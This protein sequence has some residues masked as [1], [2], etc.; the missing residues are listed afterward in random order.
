MRRV[1]AVGVVLVM[2][3][4][5]LVGC[6]GS[7][8]GEY[9]ISGTIKDLDGIGL[10]EVNLLLEGEKTKSVATTD[11]NGKWSAKVKGTVTVIPRKEMWEFD[12]EYE[13]VKKKNSAVDFIGIPNLF[14]HKD[15]GDGEVIRT[16]LEEGQLELE[17]VPADGYTFSGWDVRSPWDPPFDF[18]ED[19]VDPEN[20][21]IISLEEPRIVTA[22]FAAIRGAYISGSFEVVH[23]FPMALEEEFADDAPAVLRGG[24]DA[25][26]E[27]S[28]EY[29]YVE[30]EFIVM[31]NSFDY[32]KQKAQFERAGYKVLDR[33][34]ALNSYLVTLDRDVKVTEE[35]SEL[36]G[37]ASVEHNGIVRPFALTIPDE[38]YYWAQWHYHQ[39]RLAQAWSVTTGSA[40]VRIGVVDTGIDKTHYQLK[41]NLDL[42][43]AYDFTMDRD[44]QDSGYHGTHVSGTIG[45]ISNI[46]GDVAGIMWDVTILP[47]KVFDGRGSATNWTVVHGMLYA[48]GLLNEPGKPYNPA[49]VDV[50]NLSLGGG[51]S[52]FEEDAVKLIDA[53]G[54]IIVAAAGND[55]WARVSYPA[56]HPE[57]IAVGAVGKVDK[58]DPRGY[59]EPPLASYSNWGSEIDIVAPGGGGRTAVKNDYVWSTTPGDDWGGAA[60]TSMAAPHVTGV[61]GLMLSNGI[62]KEQVR[63]ILYRTSMEINLP[64]P[65]IYFGHG[66]INAY[67]A[68][69]D[70]REIRFIQGLREGESVDVIA[71]T[72]IPLKGG[73]FRLDLV[74]GDYQF[75]AWIDANKNGIVDAGDYYAETPV[76]EIEPGSSWSWIDEI[77]EL[78][79]DFESLDDVVAADQREAVKVH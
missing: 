33:L 7:G 78:P 73:Q 20:P 34:E 24:L 25:A 61:V 28:L 43:N 14:I 65:N 59:T 37:V 11:E 5:L 66:L 21:I 31:F 71:E 44:V 36:S 23:S 75:I 46:G 76:L 63:E 26:D 41:D 18:V 48:A 3:G 52:Q 10:P 13:V 39:I 64:T 62:P 49:P 53:A 67:W 12:K 72:S 74:E 4:L 47:V 70:V 68:V 38:E 19:E 55:G 27:Y 69:N 22:Y 50:I 45:A 51:W 40:D 16:I 35:L 8:T 9:A 29:E 15:G 77:G 58:N 32:D 1:L 6:L 79:F 2:I 17:A 42:V 30:D 54:V 56:A 60:G 57:V